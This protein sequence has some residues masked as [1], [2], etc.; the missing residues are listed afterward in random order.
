MTNTLY[1]T[2]TPLTDRQEKEREEFIEGNARAAL[3]LEL[4]GLAI[5]ANNTIYPE[6]IED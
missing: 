5:K 1:E 4:A 6:F 3:K 2:A